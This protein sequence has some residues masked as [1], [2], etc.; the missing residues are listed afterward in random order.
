M[1]SIL[2]RPSGGGAAPAPSY[3]NTWQPN[4][5]WP[6]ITAPAEGVEGVYKVFNDGYN[7][8]IIGRG[9]SG[10]DFTIDA[11]DGSAP[12]NTVAQTT[13]YDYDYSSISATEYTDP[14]SGRLVKYLKVTITPITTIN[15]LDLYNLSAKAQNWAYIEA[16]IPNCTTLRVATFSTTFSAFQHLEALHVSDV[17]SGCTL[18]MTALVGLRSL[19][20][21]WS[22]LN[23]GTG[24]TLFRRMGA[25]YSVADIVLNGGPI[26]NFW[27]D[28]SQV[29]EFGDID[30]SA[31][32]STGNSLFKL[33]SFRKIGTVTLPSV[34][35]NAQSVF[36]GTSSC[37][38]EIILAGGSLT[39]LRSLFSDSGTPKGVVMNAASVTNTSNVAKN[40]NLSEGLL[41]NGCT[42][43]WSVANTNM[44]TSG[45]SASFTAMGT[46]SGAQNITVTGTPFGVALSASDAG[47]VAAAAIA[48]GKGYTIV[49]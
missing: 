9:S 12:F 2:T 19:Q 47:A 30:L 43:G 46:A 33:A 38:S 1:P 18:A 45:A 36:E 11:G 29:Q 25:V 35:T 10:N 20:M 27:A 16:N 13:T 48:T 14:S 6:T 21:P 41:L 32:T 31:C 40:A 8:L 24:W 5:D 17:A 23:N 4:P 7:R 15:D 3:P 42:V 49:N 37:Q 39:G 44:T 28:S 22:K 26:S 34:V